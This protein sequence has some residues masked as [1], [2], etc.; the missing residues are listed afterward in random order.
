MAL[1][2]NEKS[3]FTA[4]TGK[5]SR[6]VRKLLAAAVEAHTDII[7]TPLF[8]Q[9]SDL[10]ESLRLHQIELERQNKELRRTQADLEA[11]RAHYMELYDLALVGYATIDGEHNP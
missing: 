9:A 1:G 10:L 8:V 2:L 4:W 3:H 5:P 6:T 11:S 7:D